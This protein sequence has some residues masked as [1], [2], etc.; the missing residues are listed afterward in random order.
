MP[1][2]TSLDAVMEDVLNE[3]EGEFEASGEPSTK[4]NYY[5]W[6]VLSRRDFG[7]PEELVES[8]SVSK[9]EMHTPDDAK[10][11]HSAVVQMAYKT[12]KE[13][14]TRGDFTVYRYRNGY[15]DACSYVDLAD[16]PYLQIRDC[17]GFLPE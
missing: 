7:G 2:R 3:L 4:K 1:R 16:P 11:R 13:K 10:F 8:L 15:R 14:G 6:R 17:L 12:L 9:S 5:R